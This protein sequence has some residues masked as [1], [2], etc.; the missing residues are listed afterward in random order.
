MKKIVLF[1]KWG[2]RR[3]FFSWERGGGRA[4]GAA[5]AAAAAAATAGVAA[6]ATAAAKL[7]QKLGYY[8]YAT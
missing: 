1:F 2:T 7:R 6:A 8:I 4:T 5:A 3:Q